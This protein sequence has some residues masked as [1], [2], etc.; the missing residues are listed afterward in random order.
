MSKISKMVEKYNKK[1][2]AKKYGRT[3]EQQEYR[4]NLAK[5]LKEKRKQWTPWIELAKALTDEKKTFRY[6]DALGEGRKAELEIAE[7]IIENWYSERLIEYLDK[8][9]SSDHQ[10]IAEKMIENSQWWVVVKYLEKFDWLNHEKIVEK[11]IENWASHSIADSPK[12]LKKFKILD[13]KLLDALLRT[14]YAWVPEYYLKNCEGLTH[15]E[16]AERWA[17]MW[18]YRQLATNLDKFEWL[19][20]NDWLSKEIA[21]AI[22]ESQGTVAVDYVVENLDKFELKDDKEIMEVV[23]KLRKKY[24]GHYIAY[25]LNKAWYWDF[26]IKHPEIFWPKKEK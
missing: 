1:R 17:D 21:I 20:K 13:P 25:G 2:T 18:C 7:G 10:Q 12:N 26:V 14:G 9:K 19:S 11:L 8:F 16:I 22:I 3:Y 4:N 15:K 24:Y 6:L 23:E 5:C